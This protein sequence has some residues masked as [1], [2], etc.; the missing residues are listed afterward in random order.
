MLDLTSLPTAFGPLSIILVLQPL[1][2][3]IT[4]YYM[5][6]TICRNCN[7]PS[8]PN[9]VPQP[10]PFCSREVGNRFSSL[11]YII[12]T[13]M[14]K[15]NDSLVFYYIKPMKDIRRP[16][17]CLVQFERAIMTLGCKKYHGME[18]FPQLTLE[19]VFSSPL[20]VYFL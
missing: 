12:N 15:C 3:R 9:R 18:C 1:I 11:W 10:S 14:C 7:Q 2:P 17:L 8:S 5:T 6:D 4:N 19:A 20:F 16:Q 13:Y